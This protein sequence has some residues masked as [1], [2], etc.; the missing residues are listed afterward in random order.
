MKIHYEDLLRFLISKEPIKNISEKLFQL[1]HEHEISNNIFDLEL[2]A[3]RGDCLSVYG[4][5][6]DLNTFYGLKNDLGIYNGE[7]PNMSFNFKNTSP[8]NCPNI[9]FLRIEIDKKV[10]SEKYSDYME[11]YF[12]NMGINKNNFFTDISNYLSYEIGQPSHCYNGEIIRDGITFSNEHCK[13]SFQTLLDKEVILDGKVCIFKH[14]DRIVNIA[15]VMGDKSSSCNEETLT[16]LVEFANFKPEAIIGKALKYNLHSEAARKFER[17]VDPLM[18]DLALRRFIKITEDHAD[19]K[20]LEVFSYGRDT[21]KSRYIPFNPTSINKIL[22]TNIDKTEIEDRL[23]DLYFKF[24]ETIEIP[25]FRNDIISENDLAEEVA[26]SIGYNN[27]KQEETTI[28]KFNLSSKASKYYKV[29]EKLFRNG[30][31]E[32]I[33]FPFARERQDISIEIDNPLDSNKKYLRSNLKN[34]LIDNLIYNERRQKDSIKLFEIS[35]IYTKD[36]NTETKLGIIATGRQGYNYRDFSN[37]ISKL[38]LDHIFKDYGI[39]FNEISRSDLDTKRKE[40][41]FYAEIEISKYSDKSENFYKSHSNFKKYQKISDFPS[42]VRDFSFSVTNFS[43]LDDIYSHIDSYKHENLKN[44]FIFDFFK[45]DKTKEIKL[46]YRFIFQSKDKTLSEEQ[47]SK[48]T[49]EILK[50]ILSMK[51]VSIPGM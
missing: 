39:E 49:D 38:S 51:G 2:T 46:G 9:T 34:S 26:R 15:G 33:N 21:Y 10:S 42:S 30:F 17:G 37:K 36:N 35:D 47:I 45:N 7:I 43:K 8:E 24:N 44:A 27:I 48:I 12:K 11:N 14:N 28:P 6:R 32:V 4:L 20:S 40:K 3:N 5:A 41:I 25:S 31:Y 19:I 50:P 16:A 1:G 18:Q 13:E 29:K 22:G 23:K